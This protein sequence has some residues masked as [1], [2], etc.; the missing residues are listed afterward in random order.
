MCDTEW[1]EAEYLRKIREQERL[2]YRTLRGELLQVGDSIIFRHSCFSICDE[3]RIEDITMFTVVV[4]IPLDPCGCELARF[5]FSA[6]LMNDMD[7]RKA[8]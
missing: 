2:C 5:A 8:V 6:E 7:P 3:F 1:Y 4:S